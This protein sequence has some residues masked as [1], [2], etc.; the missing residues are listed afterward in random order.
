MD[1][2]DVASL[3]PR[4]LA[5][6]VVCEVASFVCCWELLRI[7][8]R[9]EKWTDVATSQL[10]GN[11]VS[12]V[13]PGGGAA[14]AAVELKLLVR[15]GFDVPTA[16]A[17]MTAAGVLSTVGFLALPL[18]VLPGLWTGA[19]VDSTL[20]AGVWLSV[21]LLVVVVGTVAI[22]MRD[23]VLIGLAR[24]AQRIVDVIGRG[25]GPR[26]LVH[27]AL[28]QRDLMYVVVRQRLGRA[29]AATVGQAAAGYLALYLVLAA[30][31]LRP[32]LIVVL[33][34]F[35]VANI[36][37]MIPITPA[38]LGFVEA[39]LA[40]VLSMAGVPTATALVVALAYR[41]ISSWLP[42]LVGC[43]AFVSVRRRSGVRASGGEGDELL[44]S[45][46]VVLDEAPATQLGKVGVTLVRPGGDELVAGEQVDVSA[47]PVDVALVA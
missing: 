4:W 27:H 41:L 37:G 18:L 43:L 7:V 22:A 45:R 34:A 13:V 30:A 9:S 1:L 14:G 16:V 5:L 25:R 46:L 44:L 32:N 21:A 39:G 11:A 15:S 6:A 26:D 36:A 3:D 8:L 47:R 10:A 2:G 28:T 24:G 29:L 38:G 17:G 33:A 40:G 31:G 20:E 23:R 35:G 19:K 12:Q 42:A